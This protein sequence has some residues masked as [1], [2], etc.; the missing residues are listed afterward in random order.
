MTKHQFTPIPAF[1]DSL[2]SYNLTA[3]TPQ[4]LLGNAGHGFVCVLFWKVLR[5][6][7]S[8]FWCRTGLYQASIFNNPAALSTIWTRLPS[9]SSKMVRALLVLKN[10]FSSINS[11]RRM[12]RP[13]F[14]CPQHFKSRWE[15]KHPQERTEALNYKP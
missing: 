14:K 4:Q 13:H 8:R 3:K 7:E 1:P 5:A 15:L 6:V 10:S 12:D 11:T 9:K 2:F